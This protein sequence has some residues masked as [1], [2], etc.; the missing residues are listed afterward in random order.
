M[1]IPIVFGLPLHIWGGMLIFFLILIQVAGGLKLICI[2]FVWHKR[3]AILI[4]FL[5]LLHGLAGI[6][7]W[8]GW[9]IIK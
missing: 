9:I 1:S 8:N 4:V 7:L 6:A 5:G 2:P 3:V